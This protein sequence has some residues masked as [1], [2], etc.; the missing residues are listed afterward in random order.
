MGNIDNCFASFKVQHTFDVIR[1]NPDPNLCF[2]L[3]EPHILSTV[4]GTRN[5]EHFVFEIAEIQDT[6]TVVPVRRRTDMRRS[7][8]G[9]I[10][11]LGPLSQGETIEVIANLHVFGR[12]T[13]L[14]QIIFDF[15]FQSETG[16]SM[17]SLNCNILNN[18]ELLNANIANI[19]SH[20]SGSVLIVT[21]SM[22]SNRLSIVIETKDPIKPFAIPAKIRG[23]QY[24]GLGL[25]A[26]P[27][28]E[29]DNSASELIILIDNSGS[30]SG[31]NL[32]HAK[33]AVSCLIKKFPASCYFNI[34]SFES[35]YEKFFEETILCSPENIQA[36]EVRL[37]ALCAR[38]GT[39]LL[40][41]I[42]FLYSQ[43]RR[44][45]FIRQLF[46][47]T[48]GEVSSQQEILSLV[49]EDRSGSRIMTFGIGSDC[50]R[51][52]VEE[53]AV[54]SGGHALFVESANIQNAIDTQWRFCS[55]SLRETIVN[56]NV[57]LTGLTE[58]EVSP[59]PIPSLFVNSITNVFIRTSELSIT[60]S[61][62][63]IEGQS[64]STDFSETL[65]IRSNQ[66]DV[67]LD[68]FM[69]ANLIRDQEA[70][71]ASSDPDK[72]QEVAARIVSES[73]WAGVPSILTTRVR[74]L[75]DRVRVGDPSLSNEKRMESN[76][77][78]VSSP[79]EPL[80]I[81]VSSP[82]EPVVVLAP[83]V[84]HPP[85]LQPLTE[86]QEASRERLRIRIQSQNPGHP[87]VQTLAPVRRPDPLPV[88]ARATPSVSQDPPPLLAAA[89]ASLR[90]V[91]IVKT[92]DPK[93]ED[94]PLA[95]T[96]TTAHSFGSVAR[97]VSVVQSTD[98]PKEAVNTFDFEKAEPNAN[99]PVYRSKVPGETSLVTLKELPGRDRVPV[100][101]QN[102]FLKMMRIL[103]ALQHPC[104]HPILRFKP[105]E[106]GSKAVIC[107]EYLSNG[108]LADRIDN[109]GKFPTWNNT[110]KVKTIVGTVLGMR[111]LH[112]QK[113]IHGALRPSNIL[114][115]DE[116]NPRI[117]D[118]MYSGLVDI[119]FLPKVGM[120]DPSVS[121]SPREVENQK[122]TQSADV[123]SWGLIAIA[124]L[125][126]SNN[127]ADNVKRWG[128]RN[129][130]LLDFLHKQLFY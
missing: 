103:A 115:D 61:T 77:T 100:S 68:K 108:S 78:V 7:T 59:L 24:I 128:K 62:V 10:L 5:A 23:K 34:I 127:A 120:K 4:F 14:N 38:G 48:D 51:V 90:P 18:Q 125:T 30:M 70:V 15:P 124:V 122:C 49:S 25:K 81:T 11:K 126:N 111:Y 40:D 105:P 22:I 6:Q 96:Q 56:V 29:S 97:R 69:A 33:T 117:A 109:P 55:E 17:I 95:T 99:C 8:N 114:F 9:V 66:T 32:N 80:P 118:F 16:N 74:R 107:T 45:G 47:L 1:N 106:S 13:G 39:V 104:I 71:L 101:V 116:N 43:P 89:R 84:I 64:G 121:Y 2:E 72:L 50:D 129:G 112:D 46:L 110:T 35:C 21:E 85:V 65:E 12:Q 19:S 58:I 98:S 79:T 92:P 57:R 42:R 130:R 27:A 28:P 93:P 60:P 37:Q 75:L 63:I 94:I 20:F 83:T 76:E 36:A 82:T 26:P 54:R 86:A 113:Q 119:N 73:L 3:D 67:E 87:I 102:D 53:L 41:P 44:R 123:F 91:S 88:Q 52:F 31:E